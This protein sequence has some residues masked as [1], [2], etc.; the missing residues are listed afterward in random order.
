MNAVNKIKAA[1]KIKYPDLYNEIV[2][3]DLFAK[4]IKYHTKCYNSF[5]YGY[6]SSMRNTEKEP[7]DDD[8]L[9][10]NSKSDW[11]AVKTFI[12][13]QVLL[14][15]KAFSMHFLHGLYKL[16]PNDTCYRNKLKTRICNE[17]SELLTFLTPANNH[18]E[19]VIHTSV[20]SEQSHL[21]DD[22][23]LRNAAYNLHQDILN[24]ANQLPEPKWLPMPDELTS[25][26]RNPPK[27][28]RD[29]LTHLLKPEKY[30]VSG[31]VNV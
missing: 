9:Q 10:P 27:S 21:S 26:E 4:E 1:A 25:N 16:N 3:L 6:S 19:V 30:S 7:T 22:S 20:L 5:T 18:A 15:K 12:S 29:F 11:E 24:F 31:N 2:D 14:E 13:H 23:I 17:F 8:C 28:V